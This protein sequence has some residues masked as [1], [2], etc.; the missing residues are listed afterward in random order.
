MR[1]YTRIRNRMWPAIS[2]VIFNMKDF[3]EVVGIPI[4]QISEIVQDKEGHVYRKR[5]GACRT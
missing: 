2:E 3:K 1:I 4:L 5:L